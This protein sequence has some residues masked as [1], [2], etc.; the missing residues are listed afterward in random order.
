M[1]SILIFCFVYLSLL[2]GLFWE[3]SFC[4]YEK[5]ETYR[6]LRVMDA[7]RRLENFYAEVVI[8]ENLTSSIN[9]LHLSFVLF[10]FRSQVF[11]FEIL[12]SVYVKKRTNFGF[13][14][15]WLRIEN[16][17]T[18]TKKLEKLST[19]IYETLANVNR[20]I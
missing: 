7:N 10:S 4:L 8:C 20:F 11:S 16:F 1:K 18:L 19:D 12:R 17:E 2:T 15:L 13:W 5:A 3:T 6:I 14:V 9:S